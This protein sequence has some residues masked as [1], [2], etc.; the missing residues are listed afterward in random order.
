MEA[1]LRDL[2]VANEDFDAIERAFNVF[3]PFEAVGM[4]RQEIRHSH[5]LAYILDPL[6]PH[7]FGTACLKAL[8][9]CVSKGGFK[10]SALSPLSAH[11]MN[12]EL[13]DV[14]REWRRVDLL[15]VIGAE[16]L[17]IAIE[18]KIDSLE[19]YGQLS[20]YR[21][22]VKSE[23]PHAEGWRHEF[24]FLTKRGDQAEEPGWHNVEL[25]GLITAFEGIYIKE[26]G[27]LSARSMLAAYTAMM[28]RHHL[29]DEGLQ[30]IARR[31]WDR[32]RE[33]LDFL[34]ENR[35]DTVDGVFGRIFNERDEIALQMSNAVGLSVL[36]DKSTPS[37]IRFAIA[38]W[39][40]FPGMLRGEGW[41]ESRRLLLLEFECNRRNG[42][43]A[44]RFVIGPGDGGARLEIYR[45][46]ERG[47]ITMGRRGLLAPSY[48]RLS[49]KTL[50]RN[51]ETSDGKTD[52]LFQ[53]VREGLIEYARRHVPAYDRALAPAIDRVA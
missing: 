46:L 50:V 22:A 34:M 52:E 19:H 17:I 9:L 15:I 25:D 28:R 40:D 31:L 29:N 7:G 5:F 18:L 21:E 43:V 37:F 16:K 36:V 14:R 27:V 26:I 44:A 20:R 35:P 1:A 6:R 38:N 4:V 8:L 51:M 3:C 41:T 11:L 12:L 48:T 49:S 10:D 39:D 42:L 33:A 24:I 47:G 32:H 30:V 53:S 23:W 13:A 45:N 2:L